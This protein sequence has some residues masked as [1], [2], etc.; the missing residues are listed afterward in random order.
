MTTPMT[1]QPDIDELFWLIDGSTISYTRTDEKFG[2]WHKFG[3]VDRESLLNDLAAY[4]QKRETAAQDAIVDRIVEMADPKVFCRW[5]KKDV[6]HFFEN[7]GR[8]TREYQELSN[9]PSIE[10]KEK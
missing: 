6:A 1:P 5:T 4:C 10:T 2:N 7:L 9:Q 3:V 8:F